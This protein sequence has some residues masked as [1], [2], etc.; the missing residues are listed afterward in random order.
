M[1]PESDD[2][3]IGAAKP[4]EVSGVTLSVRCDLRLPERCEF[5]LPSWKIE[6]VPK[7]A[8]DEYRRPESGKDDIWPAWK[9][10]H[11]CAES[12]AV[13]MQGGAHSSLKGIVSAPN[14]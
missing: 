11:V 1:L 6:A 7:V 2:G 13:P 10:S 4:A 5:L 3:P 12:K 14:A 8:V 9:R